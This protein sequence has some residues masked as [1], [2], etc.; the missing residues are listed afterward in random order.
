[1]T[2]REEMEG[3]LQ[4]KYGD[5]QSIMQRAVEQLRYYEALADAK[6]EHAEM[7]GRRSNAA[8]DVHR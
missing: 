1:M 8:R 7:Y 2:L 6:I 4:Y 5:V 3:W